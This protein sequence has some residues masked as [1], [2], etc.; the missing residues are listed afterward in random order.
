M[1]AAQSCPTLCDFM[2]CSLPDSSVHG[3]LQA[4]ILGWIALLQGT[5]PT[6]GLNSGLLHCRQ[7]LYCLSQQVSP[8]SLYSMCLVTQSCPTLATA[9]TVAWQAPLSM[10]FSR[11]EFWSGL[12]FPSPS[13]QYRALQLAFKVC[14]CL[15][16][17]AAAAAPLF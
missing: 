13:V 4:K 1:L 3:I 5:F 6:Q 16:F 7:I 8:T 2:D 12:S 11:Q 9:Q 15:C 10:G 14:Q 17:G